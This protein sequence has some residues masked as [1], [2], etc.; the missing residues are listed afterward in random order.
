[1]TRSEQKNIATRKRHMQ[2]KNSVRNTLFFL[3]R[4]SKKTGL[5]DQF[6]LWLFVYNKHF[7]IKKPRENGSEN[8]FLSR[9]RSAAK[10]ECEP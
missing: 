2:M 3:F 7:D 4:F 6:L 1:M 9:V 10:R 5:A 8:R